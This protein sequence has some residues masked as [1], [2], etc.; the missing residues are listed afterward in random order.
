M[1]LIVQF[2][3]K[4]VGNG[5]TLEESLN[6][7]KVVWMTV[8]R[9]AVYDEKREPL[10][11]REILKIRLYS[12]RSVNVLGKGR[13]PIC[14]VCDRP[15]YGIPDLHEAIL[16]RGKVQGASDS[17][18]ALELISHPC[19]CVL[20]HHVCPDG[21]Y[22][23]SGTGGDEVLARC[24][25]QIIDWESYPAVTAWLVLYHYDIGG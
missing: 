4:R 13:F 14:P 21:Q 11:A 15:I 17:D 7:S 20:R 3:K 12:E 1:T 24:I 10:R 5:K 6:S 22:H 18:K 8:N 23:T 16:T 2:T 25:K 19:N 9:R